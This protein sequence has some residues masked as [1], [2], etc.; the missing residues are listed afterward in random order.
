MRRWSMRAAEWCAIR[1]PRIGGIIGQAPDID[2]SGRKSHRGQLGR[3]ADTDR[4][5]SAEACELTSMP[6]AKVM[7]GKFMIRILRVQ[8]RCG[9]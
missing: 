5:G 3:I 7:S 2:G 4:A 8:S 6:T 9:K 1:Q